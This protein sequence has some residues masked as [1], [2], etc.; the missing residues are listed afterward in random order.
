MTK[1]DI[2]EHIFK[3]LIERFGEKIGDQEYAGP[4]VADLRDEV[5]EDAYGLNKVGYGMN[6]DGVRDN[7]ILDDGKN[8]NVDEGEVDE[9][10][11]GPSTRTAKKMAKTIKGKYGKGFK[12]KVKFAKKAGMKNPEGF[13]GWLSQKIEK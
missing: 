7:T 13:A 2:V 5:D 1:N 11:S 4:G 9:K 3:K 10:K 8:D 12:G 6:T